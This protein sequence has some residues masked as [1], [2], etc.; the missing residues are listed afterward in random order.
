M[1][2]IRVYKEDQENRIHGDHLRG[3]GK[4]NLVT[5]A[6]TQQQTRRAVLGVLQLPNNNCQKP[7]T[8]SVGVSAGFSRRLRVTIYKLLEMCCRVDLCQL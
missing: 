6:S 2:T 8:K 5:G 1:A 7:N 4:E 3:R